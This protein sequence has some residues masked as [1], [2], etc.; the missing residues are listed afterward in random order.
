MAENITL[1]IWTPERT[2]FNQKV[3]RVVL[4]TGQNTLTVIDDR[5]PTSMMIYAGV[6]QIL[7]PDDSVKDWYFIDKGVADV[8]QNVCQISTAHL[9]HHSQIDV[10]KALEFKEKEPENAVFYNMIVHY[11]QAFAD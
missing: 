2:A 6:M 4:P 7:N 11:L 10:E 1:Q 8:A 3:Y 5:A 9:L